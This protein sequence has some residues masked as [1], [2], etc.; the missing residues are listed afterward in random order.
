MSTCLS[1][2]RYQERSERC[3]IRLRLTGYMHA[4]DVYQE[5]LQSLG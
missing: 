3:D 4:R 5:A 2:L 1:L